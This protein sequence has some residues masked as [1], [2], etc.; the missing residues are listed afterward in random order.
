MERLTI[1]WLLLPKYT[2]P[3]QQQPLQQQLPAFYAPV[4]VLQYLYVPSR[5]CVSCNINKSDFRSDH[6]R[7]KIGKKRRKKEQTLGNGHKYNN[8]L[9]SR[10]HLYPAGRLAMLQRLGMERAISGLTPELLAVSESMIAHRQLGFWPIFFTWRQQL[11]DTS[12]FS[13]CAAV[14]QGASFIAS[15]SG[16]DFPHALAPSTL[17]SPAMLTTI[18]SNPRRQMNFIGA[19]IPV[20]HNAANP[21]PNDGF[22]T[23]TRAKKVVP[24]ITHLILI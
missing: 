22:Y 9:H 6:I 17:S 2:K 13:S 21:F 10:P 4:H 1:C 5:Q 7:K 20:S 18:T 11:S 12:A 19:S 16:E 24:P 8:E 23:T 14:A 3:K 15:L